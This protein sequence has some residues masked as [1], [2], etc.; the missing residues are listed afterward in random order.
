VPVLGSLDG[1]VLGGDRSALRAVLADPRLEGVRDAAE[2]RVIEVPEPRLDVLRA[3]PERYLST[4]IRPTS[5]S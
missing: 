5:R 3:A 4:V 2:E 1:V